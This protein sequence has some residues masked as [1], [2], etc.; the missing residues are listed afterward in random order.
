MLFVLISTSTISTANSEEVIEKIAAVVNDQLILESEL[1]KELE[2]TIEHLQS[3]RAKIPPKSLLREKVLEHLILQK[4]QMWM[5]KKSGINIDDEQLNDA[6]RKIASSN[7]LSISQ[8]GEAINSQGGDFEQ[9][10]EKI[11]NDLLVRQLTTRFVAQ[12][13]N[14]SQKEVD[15]YLFNLKNSEKADK[16]FRVAHLLIG[17][18][19]AASTE[20]IKETRKKAQEVLDKINNG[21]DFTEM[22]VS[23]SD[24]AQALKGGVLDW[25]T[26]MQL[27][28]IFAN[29][30]PSMEKGQV[31]EIINSPSG[32]HIIK[33]VDIKDENRKIVNQSKCRHILIVPNEI[34]PTEK[35]KEKLEGL[36]E[37]I[38][39][40]ES[41]TDIAKAHS[42]DKTSAISGGEMDWMAPGV[43]V[44]EFEKQI[45]SLEI[46]EVSPVFKTRYGWHIVEVLGRREHD[47]T[48][49]FLEKQAVE[50]I[51][52]RKTSEAIQIWLRQL[53]DEAYVEIKG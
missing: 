25:R 14:V 48:K 26:E 17:T 11:R 10:R 18:P 24:G 16:K 9:F 52:K 53:R 2:F 6:I 5:A 23:Y 8:L 27:P 3:S 30:V 50:D 49:A 36:R 21:A 40:G 33:L 22:V 28:T 44:P 1:Q 31:S 38:I 13:I 4:L 7:N 15:N 43:F 29:I 47:D 20:Q 39:Q 46:N 37:R 12:K 19:E 42:D 35:A 45:N 41:F 51:R 34:L 32:F